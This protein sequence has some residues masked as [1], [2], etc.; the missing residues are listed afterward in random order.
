MRFPVLD[1]RCTTEYLNR[2][3]PSF[4]PFLGMMRHSYISSRSLYQTLFPSTPPSAQPPNWT[5]SR[6]RRQHLLTL[7]IPL[8]LDEFLPR[9]NGKALPALQITT[10]P[11]SAPPGPR[12]AP[13]GANASNASASNSRA[14][15]PRAGTPVSATRSSAAAQLALGPKPKLDEARIAELMNLRPGSS[16][17]ILTLSLES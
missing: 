12:P 5:R 4:P 17:Q 7:G 8:N 6:I 16:R 10:R 13:G 2:I 3:L 1:I 9:A 11:M 15:T 14:G